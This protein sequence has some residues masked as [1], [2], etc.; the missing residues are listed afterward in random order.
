[1]AGVHN[2]TMQVVPTSRSIAACPGGDHRAGDTALTAVHQRIC[3]LGPGAFE[4]LWR[5]RHA[6]CRQRRAAVVPGDFSSDGSS[7]SRPDGRYDCSTIH[8]NYTCSACP[9][10]ALT[11]LDRV[12]PWFCPPARPEGGF[13]LETSRKTWRSFAPAEVRPQVRRQCEPSPQAD[14][15]WRFYEGSRTGEDATSGRP[16]GST[17]TFA[18]DSNATSAGVP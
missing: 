12:R 2:P 17:W 15:T 1:M 14:G 8:M 4:R 18:N 13:C 16:R 6:G 9:V 10:H 5:V 7:Y 11:A 3:S